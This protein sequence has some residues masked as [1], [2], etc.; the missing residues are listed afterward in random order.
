[1]RTQLVHI[2]LLAQ[3]STMDLDRLTVK[4]SALL[5]GALVVGVVILAITVLLPGLRYKGGLVNDRKGFELL[6]TNA[7]KR[8]QFG[9][10]GLLDVAFEKV[11]SFY[12]QRKTLLQLHLATQDA[13]GMTGKHK[14]AFYMVTDNGIE[15]IVNSR[16]AHEIRNDERFSISAY[17]EQVICA[18]RLLLPWSLT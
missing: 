3:L 15:M 12:L 2:I 16:Y 6:W 7:K 8:F 4:E 14:D 18:T 11:R 10:R 5:R 9:A 17:N 13:D 1:M